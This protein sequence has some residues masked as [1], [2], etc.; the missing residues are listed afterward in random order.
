MF[1]FVFI[2]YSLCVQI[3]LFF[4]QAFQNEYAHRKLTDDETEV[5]TEVFHWMNMLAPR[6][7]LTFHVSEI[8]IKSI[9]MLHRAVTIA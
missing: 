7:K 2:Y 3:W 8:M 6:L 4:L 9:T 5:D 1:Y